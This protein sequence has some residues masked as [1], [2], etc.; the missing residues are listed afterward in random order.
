MPVQPKK[1]SEWANG[2]YSKTRIL[3]PGRRVLLLFV[4]ISA[5]LTASAEGVPRWQVERDGRIYGSTP[6]EAA[7][8]YLEANAQRLGID[9]WNFRAFATVNWRQ[10]RVVRVQVEDESIPL[11]GHEIKIM[12]NPD[13]SIRFGVIDVPERWKPRT[14]SPAITEREALETVEDFWRRRGGNV[15][16]GRAKAELGFRMWSGRPVLTYRVLAPVGLRGYMHYVNAETGGMLSTISTVFDALGRVFEANPITTPDTIDATL[17]NLDD[18]TAPGNVLKGWEGHLEAYTHTGGSV[19][20]WPDVD[21]EHLALGD[22]DGNFLYDA[23]DI[24]P[25]YTEPFTEVNLYYHANNAM[26]YFLDVHDLEFPRRLYAFAK[27][28]EQ[29]Q[30][31][32]NAFFTPVSLGEA[33]IALG[34]GAQ[35]DYGYDG[36]VI[37]HEF[38]HFVVDTV[39]ELKYIDEYF[40][41]W[42]R[43]QMPGA[44]HEGYADYWSSTLMGDPVVGEYALGS[45]ARNMDNNLI[46]P[47]NMIGMPHQDGEVAGGAFWETR[48]L[49][50]EEI[51]DQLIFGAL[52]LLTPNGTFKDVAEGM[53]LTSQTLVTDDV[54]TQQQADDVSAML[55]SRG[56]I[57]CGRYLDFSEDYHPRFTN[58]GFDMMA[59]Q[60]G[61]SC[62]QIRGFMP[63]YFPGPFQFR[64]TTPESVEGLQYVV[65]L[66]QTNI[67]LGDDFLYRIQI[68]RDEMVHFRLEAFMGMMNI[69]IPETFDYETEDITEKDARIIISP[70]SQPELLPNTEYY[71]T[72]GNRSCPTTQ[73]T[74]KLSVEDYIPPEEPDAAVEHDAFVEQDAGDDTAG[75]GKRGCSCRVLPNGTSKE[76]PAALI[77]LT[78]LGLVIRRKRTR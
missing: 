28:H 43:S 22:E 26:E 54:M 46:C 77:L 37:L 20:Q 35:L 4:L 13:G 53:I 23:T 60:M 65:D 52:A 71:I 14:H 62:E 56:M 5:F 44:L 47:D 50:G 7:T 51:A 11:F 39:A 63:Y 49:V 33:V 25:V 34:Q 59:A 68:R 57:R 2:R 75:S 40:D 3:G 10:Y 12:V 70:E 17:T 36:D 45:H 78:L 1:H 29:G 42:G 16:L 48:T 38:G 21:Y 69:S 6:E 66:E 74:V 64:F 67:T 31:Y 15:F 19:Q 27:Y 41:E 58:I 32:E 9:N 55:E 24:H 61:V 73:A 30:P 8:H 76:L 72:F 18:V